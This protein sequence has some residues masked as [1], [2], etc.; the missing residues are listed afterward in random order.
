MV[1]LRR[2]LDNAKTLGVQKERVAAEHGLELG[3]SGMVLGDRLAF[4]AL[5]DTLYLR[6]S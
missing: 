3:R 1:V 2:R 6:G 4:D 5:F